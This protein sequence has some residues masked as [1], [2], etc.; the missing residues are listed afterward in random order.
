MDLLK[1]YASGKHSFS[2]LAQELN[3][4][5]HRT[6]KGKPFTAS[7]VSTALNNPFYEG[8]T[9][10]HRGRF[11]EETREGLYLVPEEVKSLWRRCQE[12]RAERATGGR[13]SPSSK[14][15]LVYPLTGVL[16]CDNCGEPFHGVAL[17]YQ[18]ERHLRMWH[19]RRRCSMRP[20]S[21]AA[22][23]VEKEFAERVL[24]C[25][26][27]EDGWRDAILKAMASEGP[28]PDRSV[29]LTRIR[30]A[31]ANL[32]KQHLWGAVTDE[33]FKAAYKGFE[34]QLRSLE[35][36]DRDP[37]TPNLDRAAELLQDISTL[38]THPGV[39]SGQKRDMAREV[40]EEVR[41]RDGALTAV[42]PKPVYAP[43]FAY[44]IW[45][46]SNVGGERSS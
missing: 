6:N 35:T 2:T 18:G 3:A 40:F 1:G 31:I 29:E 39:T 26:E 46:N 25:I 22:N 33:E 27:L 28:K 24:E 20:T 37:L 5:G 43:L 11:D 10:Y 9:R 30:G 36:Y 34:R 15:H 38:W 14:G 21:A 17:T 4:K 7:S 42:K 44:S 12:V 13:P 32:R 19:S 41:I 16:T 23:R 8:K 45:E